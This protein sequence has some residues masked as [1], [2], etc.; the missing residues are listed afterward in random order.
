MSTT[1]SIHATAPGTAAPRQWKPAGFQVWIDWREFG[2][3]GSFAVPAGRKTFR[4]SSPIPPQYYRFSSLIG[5]LLKLD[6]AQ[7]RN[8]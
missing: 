3:C 1:G 4:D 6:F 5:N 7:L 8:Y 2:G